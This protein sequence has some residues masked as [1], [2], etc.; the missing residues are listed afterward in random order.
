MNKSKS[1][2]WE[3]NRH[4]KVPKKL[5]PVKTHVLR[6]CYRLPF[7][8]ETSSVILRIVGNLCIHCMSS[9]MSHFHS[10]KKKRW[11]VFFKTSVRS[12]ALF[13][14]TAIQGVWSQCLLESLQKTPSPCVKPQSSEAARQPP[15]SARMQP[16]LPAGTR[17]PGLGLQ[18]CQ[19]KAGHSSA[20]ER[21]DTSSGHFQSLKEK[22]GT[23]W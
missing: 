9:L 23:G 15:H 13:S 7:I 22:K 1:P 11:N 6:T 3:G 20:W 21:R 19:A 8:G 10:E 18:I 2:F 12:Q 5:D 4:I 16:W 14:S 17:G